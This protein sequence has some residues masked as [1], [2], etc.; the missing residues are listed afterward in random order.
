MPNQLKKSATLIISSALEKNVYSNNYNYKIILLK[1]NSKMR[2]SPNFHVYPGGKY[3]KTIDESLDWLDIFFNTKQLSEIRSNPILLRKRFFN[4]LINQNSLGNL[5]I[6]KHDD[7]KLLLPLEISYRLCAIRETFEETGLL[8]AT[9]KSSDNFKETKSKILTNYCKDNLNDIKS[10][11]RLIK[12]DSSEFI[13]MFLKL[14][15]MPDI[16]GLHE[17]SNWITPIH[18]KIRFDTYFFTCFLPSVPSQELFDINKDEVDTLEL[19]TPSEALEK[20]K[21]KE[22]KFIPPQLYEFN[23][24]QRFRDFDKFSEYSFTRQNYG[25][26]P[27]LPKFVNN[28]KIGLLPGDYM[29]ETIKEEGC[30]S[31]SIELHPLNSNLKLNRIIRNFEDKSKPMYDVICN[32]DFDEVK[33]CTRIL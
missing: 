29:Y 17:W 19:Y 22:I 10:W 12:K 18:E 3:D 5:M 16:F 15:L 2:S 24:I 1:R 11:H 23:R 20:H 33:L 13:N 25:L 32:Y 30:N 28:G 8:L 4:G 9:N 7:E 14:N 6:S 21:H 27:W 31:T 26:H